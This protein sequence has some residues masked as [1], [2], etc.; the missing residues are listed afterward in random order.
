LAWLAAVTVAA[1]NK[2]ATNCRFI[3]TNMGL[4]V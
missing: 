3:F 2:S 1:V 4:K